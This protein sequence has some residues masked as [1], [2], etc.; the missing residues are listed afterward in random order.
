M[1]NV[2]T[3]LS[4]A[5]VAVTRSTGTQS[6]RA[7]DYLRVSAEEQKKGY[8]V[9]R[10]SRK[11]LRHIALKQWTHIATYKDEGVSGSLE[12]AHRGDL[13]RLMEDA[14]QI[15]RPFDI[16]V[17]PD[18]RSA[19]RAVPS[20]GG[21]GPSK[22]SGCTSPTTTT[23]PRWKG[24]RRCAVTPTTPRPSGRRSGIAHR[25]GCRRR[26][27]SRRPR[28]S[29]AGLPTATASPTKAPRAPTW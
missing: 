14:Q 16:V 10:Q 18:G 26:R 24:A 19:A 12:A 28:T 27:N 4:S 6:L 21:S 5:I 23:T 25:A 8:G 29:A 3:P 1:S 22:T 2:S 7:V 9:A 20:G 11:T 13:K 17:V 15:P